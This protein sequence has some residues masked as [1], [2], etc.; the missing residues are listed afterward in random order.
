[1]EEN[2]ENLEAAM[3]D[4]SEQVAKL[5]DTVAEMTTSLEKAVRVAV[6]RG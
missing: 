1:M 6:A 5:A 4:L 2:L 3:Y